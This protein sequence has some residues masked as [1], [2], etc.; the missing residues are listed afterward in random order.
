MS[1]VR[2][3]PWHDLGELYRTRVGDA[4]ASVELYKQAVSLAP[5]WPLAQFNYG[6]SLRAVGAPLD[7]RVA[8]MTALRLEPP[9]AAHVYN[10]LALTFGDLNQIQ[11]AHAAFE[12]SKIE[13]GGAAMYGGGDE[14]VPG[15]GG[16]GLDKSFGADPD[17]MA[18]I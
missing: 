8:Y 18:N 16:A 15:G 3:E 7:A 17:D 10:N 4:A 6:N 13:H 9:F 12:E 14:T 11:D 2:P 5:S 1:P